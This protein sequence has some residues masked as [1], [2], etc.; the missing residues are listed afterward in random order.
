MPLRG[1]AVR[2]QQAVSALRALLLGRCRKATGSSHATNLYVEPSRFSWL[3][4][5]EITQRFDLQSAQSFAT[6][7]CT[8]CGGPVPHFTRSGREVVIPAG[9][10]DTVPDM[11]P[12]ANIFWGSRASWS[13]SGETLP[14]HDQ[15]TPDWR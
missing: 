11:V 5:E 2:G 10:L 13:C 7:C 1:G 12:Q 6:T 3:A 4:G 9:T 8:A 14:C 15:Y